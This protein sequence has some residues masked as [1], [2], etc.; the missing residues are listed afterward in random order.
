MAIGPGHVPQPVGQQSKPLEFY[1]QASFLPELIIGTI[2]LIGYEVYG[3][4]NQFH[5]HGPIITSLD[6]KYVSLRL[7]CIEYP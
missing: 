3:K 5:G 6:I 2:L 7:C 1:P 4:V